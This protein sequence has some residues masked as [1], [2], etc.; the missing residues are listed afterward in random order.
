MINSVPLSQGGWSE[1]VSDQAR[2][3][4]AGDAHPGKFAVYMVDEHGL[5][6]LG[7][8]LVAGRDFDA[9]TSA[10]RTRTTRA[11]CSSVIITQAL[12]DKLF[13]GGAV[14]KTLYAAGT[15]NDQGR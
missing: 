4:A 11:R 2:Q 10:V 12:A 1:G 8:K 9:S 14:G 13:P 15:G 6:T 5:N 3:R 7:V